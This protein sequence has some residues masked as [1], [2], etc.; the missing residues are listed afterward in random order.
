MIVQLAIAAQE[1]EAQ[2]RLTTEQG[3]T[4][5]EEAIVGALLCGHD[6]A[7]E[8]GEFLGIGARMAVDV[9][10]GL[11]ARGHVTV[12]FSDGRVEVTSEARAA[13]L[14]PD[15]RLE[16][17]TVQVEPRSFLHE[18][19]SGAVLSRTASRRVPDDAV[20]LP[21]DLVTSPDDVPRDQLVQLLQRELNELEEGP[22][23]ASRV[24]DV[25]LGPRS[26]RRAGKDRRVVVEA[27]VHLDDAGRVRLRFLRSPFG[28]RAS[29]LLEG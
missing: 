28:D 15:R 7:E 8:L 1:I 11:W 4:H 23:L 14:D 16:S 21:R 9:L 22:R 12:D 6:T 27:A 29:R 3:L 24:L 10:H 13:Q 2:V 19:I 25:S 26:T 18:P 17:G 20:V 5:L